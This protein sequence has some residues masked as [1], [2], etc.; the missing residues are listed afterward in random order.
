MD[1]VLTSRTSLR[2]RQRRDLAIWDPRE[3]RVTGA[4]AECWIG[5]GWEFRGWDPKRPPRI[6][7]MIN[8]SFGK[9]IMRDMRG[10]DQ[11]HCLAAG[12]VYSGFLWNPPS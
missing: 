5:G 8:H 9:T 3:L 12:G 10:I 7:P 11:Q 4:Q 2:S 1:F 6:P